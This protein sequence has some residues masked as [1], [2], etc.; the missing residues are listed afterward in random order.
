ME[1]SEAGISFFKIKLLALFHFQICTCVILIKIKNVNTYSIKQG[2]QTSSVK[3]QRVSI[4]VIEGYVVSVI[5]YSA[6][7]F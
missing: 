1:K 6:L 5:N 7:A 3:G 2:L 4:L